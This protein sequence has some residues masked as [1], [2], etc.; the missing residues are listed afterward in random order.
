MEMETKLKSSVQ[1]VLLSDK[2]IVDHTLRAAVTESDIKCKDTSFIFCLLNWQTVDLQISEYLRIFLIAY[3]TLLLHCVLHM[4]NQPSLNFK[5]R[6]KSVWL[7]DQM[8]G[9]CRKPEHKTVWRLNSGRLL[10]WEARKTL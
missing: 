4:Q 10:S 6:K 5:W 3:I 9:Q 2:K 8:M 1:T 7:E